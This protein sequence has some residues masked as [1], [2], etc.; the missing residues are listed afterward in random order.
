M[1]HVLLLLFLFYF[2]NRFHVGSSFLI[3]MNASFFR[4]HG[5][6]MYLFKF[7]GFRIQDCV[8]ESRVLFG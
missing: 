6:G 2:A 1:F 7:G 3:I 5:S 8:V 4:A